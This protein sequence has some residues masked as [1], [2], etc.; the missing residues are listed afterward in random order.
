[1]AEWFGSHREFYV[2]FVLVVFA[3]L[4]RNTGLDPVRQLIA[5]WRARKPAAE[6]L[7]KRAAG[8]LGFVVFAL[9]LA[10]QIALAAAHVSLS[11]SLEYSLWFVGGL[12]L[13][14]AAQW[15][16]GRI[17]RRLLGDKSE[18]PAPLAWPWRHHPPAAHG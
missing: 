13:P 8:S 17:A 7:I 1:M 14:F 6:Q 18:T 15:G 9:F 12:V 4:W 5:A 10:T 2:L 11:P 3:L 16:I